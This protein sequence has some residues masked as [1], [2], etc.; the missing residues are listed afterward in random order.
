MRIH[1]LYMLILGT[2]TKAD[3][4][5]TISAVIRT[6]STCRS[7]PW[8]VLSRLVTPPSSPPL[9]KTPLLKW[10]SRMVLRMFTSP[11]DDTSRGRA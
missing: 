11:S 7:C 1:V 8:M 4:E 10:Y 6:D 3:A 5:K 9:M 2:E